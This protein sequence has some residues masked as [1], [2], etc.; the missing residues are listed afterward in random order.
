[1]HP[2]IHD[3]TDLTPQ[4][5]GICSRLAHF[6]VRLSPGNK[7][8]LLSFLDGA[9]PI[10]R[11]VGQWIAFAMLTGDYGAKLVGIFAR[12]FSY[13]ADFLF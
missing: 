4:E 10:V 5:R 9:L 2:F 1:M 6:A 7:L 11:R 12:Y 3:C 8:L 13:I